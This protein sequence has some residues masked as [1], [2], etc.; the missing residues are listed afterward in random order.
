VVAQVDEQQPAMVADAVAPPR[1]PDRGTDIVSA[2][3]AAGVG[4]ITVHQDASDTM[5]SAIVR[6]S[7]RSSN[8]R[9]R[10]R[11]HAV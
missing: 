7:G 6:E 9:I 5:T 11:N 2:Q 8:H 3:R 4:T 10:S 1:Q